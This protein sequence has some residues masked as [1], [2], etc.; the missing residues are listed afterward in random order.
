[1]KYLHMCYTWHGE[2]VPHNFAMFS[3]KETFRKTNPS[4]SAFAFTFNEPKQLFMV[5]MVLV[6]E[7]RLP[8]KGCLPKFS[9]VRLISTI[10]GYGQHMI[11]YS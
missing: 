2:G 7:G 8:F 5:P 4:D 11:Q 3:R 1:M 6:H 9:L 10:K